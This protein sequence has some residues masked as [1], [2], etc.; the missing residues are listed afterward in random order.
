MSWRFNRSEVLD[1]GEEF[2]RLHGEWLTRALRSRR[3]YPRIPVRRVD[4]GGFDALRA[5]TNG[6]SRARR[7]WDIVLDKLDPI[8]P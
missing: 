5:R 6:P 7:W 1:K 4:E 8:E 3:D 2:R